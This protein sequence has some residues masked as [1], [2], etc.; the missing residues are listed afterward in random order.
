MPA[1][2]QAETL[3]GCL[4][5]GVWSL[6]EDWEA[7]DT[8]KKDNVYVNVLNTKHGII[9]GK[10]CPLNLDLKKEVSS[11]G[12][13]EGNSTLGSSFNTASVLNYKNVQITD[14]VMDTQVS[15]WLISDIS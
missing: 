8:V 14:A 1:R 6:R 3:S 10:N 15:I 11:P 13:H 4:E 9:T 7:G 5:I 2:C 12:L